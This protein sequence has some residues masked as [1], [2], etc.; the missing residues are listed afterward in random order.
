M[1]NA[2]YGMCPV[3][4]GTT[5]SRAQAQVVADRWLQANRPGEHASVA[6]ALPGY[7]TVHT[8]RGD[9]VAGMLSVNAATGAVW[10]HG[11]HGRFIAIN[12]DD[13][14]EGAP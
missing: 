6:D 13:T 2:I 11:W 12:E 7:Y 14:T 10:Y 5:V 8:L 1:W 4:A 3:G 9:L